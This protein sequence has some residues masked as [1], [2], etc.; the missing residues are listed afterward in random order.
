MHFNIV[1]PPTPSSYYCLFL[2]GFPAKSFI[3]V[4]FVLRV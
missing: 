3:H 2:S 4:S 1:R